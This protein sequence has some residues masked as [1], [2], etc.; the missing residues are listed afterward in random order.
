MRCYVC[1]NNFNKKDIKRHHRCYDPPVMI[2][3]CRPCHIAIHDKSR[4]DLI[5]LDPLRFFEGWFY[6]SLGFSG[7]H[8]CSYVY[9]DGK[10]LEYL[11]GPTKAGCLVML[12]CLEVQP[13]WNWCAYPHKKSFMDFVKGGGSFFHRMT[14]RERR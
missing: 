11:L 12:H 5:H 13:E 6:G 8:L 3:V 10:R 1:H 2:P 9:K 7:N 14:M 4:T